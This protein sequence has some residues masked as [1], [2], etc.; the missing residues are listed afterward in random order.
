MDFLERTLLF[1]IG[2]IFLGG[3]AVFTKQAFEDAK[4]VFESLIF[5]LVVCAVGLLLII[6][7]FT[8]P[9]S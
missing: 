5:A 7:T 6:W 3:G 2:A 8:G 4:N 9:P 1:T